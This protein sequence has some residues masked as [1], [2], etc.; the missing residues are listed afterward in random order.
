MDDFKLLYHDQEVAVA[1]VK[2]T[3]RRISGPMFKDNRRDGLQVFLRTSGKW[4]LYELVVLDR[5]DFETPGLETELPNARPSKGAAKALSPST[6]TTQPG[7]P[8]ATLPTEP[9]ATRP[10][11]K[12]EKED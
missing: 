6:A 10:A 5:V 7:N 12:P 11:K 8:P 3:I 9:P 2:Q 4:Q 1:R